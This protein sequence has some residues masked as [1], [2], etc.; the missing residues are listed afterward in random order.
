MITRID[1]RAPEAGTSPAILGWVVGD[2]NWLKGDLFLVFDSFARCRSLSADRAL[3][4]ACFVGGRRRKACLLAPPQHGG[5]RSDV[6]LLLFCPRAPSSAQYRGE[7][8]QHRHQCQATLQ[9]W[10]DSDGRR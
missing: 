3:E 2:I 10:C 8:S 1:P 9:P 5:A 6:V 4:S 7:A